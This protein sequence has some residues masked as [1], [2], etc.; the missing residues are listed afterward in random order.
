MGRNL[1]GIPGFDVKICWWR[2]LWGWFH[3]YW[4][5]LGTMIM[6]AVQ[7]M[8]TKRS[9]R[10]SIWSIYRCWQSRQCYWLV[11]KAMMAMLAISQSEDLYS[12]PAGPGLGPGPGGA[13]EGRFTIFSPP[14]YQVLHIE[15]QAGEPPDL[16]SNLSIGYQVLRSEYR[17]LQI[18][19][20][21]CCILSTKQATDLP[22]RLT[23][24]LRGA[25]GL[26]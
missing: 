8:K 18:K 15:Y 21:E 1:G 26:L 25:I 24:V 2:K 23:K 22:L 16:K 12:C 6:G 5:F 4:C 10:G 7:A 20:W 13:N 3:E 14:W 9:S 19:Y 11:I 17:V